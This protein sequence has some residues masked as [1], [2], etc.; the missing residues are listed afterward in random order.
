MSGNVID[1]QYG[2]LR[3]ILVTLPNHALPQVESYL[4]LQYA[5]LLGGEL[6][7]MPPTSPMEKWN[8]VR[9]ALKFRPVCPQKRLDID[10]LY[11]VLPEGRANHFKRLQAFLESQTEDCL[12]LNIYVPVVG[13]CTINK[14]V[15]LVLFGHKASAA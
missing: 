12:N 4:G 2:K 8:G 7:F 1:Y 6:R 15:H 14:C 3:G 10:E 13:K 11:R 5:S 9:V